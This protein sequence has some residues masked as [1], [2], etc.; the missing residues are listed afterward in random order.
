MPYLEVTSRALPATR[1]LFTLIIRPDRLLLTKR[2]EH[3][4]SGTI[5]ERPHNRVSDVIHQHQK[6][7]RKKTQPSLKASSHTCCGDDHEL[8][9]KWNQTSES[10]H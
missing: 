8:S 5:S 9:R 4:Q 7:A 6:A 10:S 1:P 2:I 3:P